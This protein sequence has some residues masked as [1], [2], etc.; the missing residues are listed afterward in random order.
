M[1]T[2]MGGCVSTGAVPRVGGA[3]CPPDTRLVCAV[4]IA[5][6]TCSCETRTHLDRFLAG[7]GS[8]AWPGAPR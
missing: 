1:L 7:F 8:S 5:A 2:G 6:T 3:D 4:S